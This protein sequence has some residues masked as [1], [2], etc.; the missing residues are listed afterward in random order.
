MAT[1]HY[2]NIGQFAFY[3]GGTHGTNSVNK[4]AVQSD[5]LLETLLATPCHTA[6]E[7]Y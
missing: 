4:E 7:K 1:Q 3:M 5:G 2:F 6:I